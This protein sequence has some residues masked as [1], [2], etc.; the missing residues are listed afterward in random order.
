MTELLPYIFSNNYVIK[1]KTFKDEKEKLFKK[2]TILQNPIDFLNKKKTKI[3]KILS[4]GSF[5]QVYNIK[6]FKQILDPKTFTPNLSDNEDVLKSMLY[7]LNIKNQKNLLKGKQP[8]F[9]TIFKEFHFHKSKS[10]STSCITPQDS[11]RN[12]NT[13]KNFKKKLNF[14]VHLPS[15]FNYIINYANLKKDELIKIRNKVKENKKE[16]KEKNEKIE[17][18]Q[19]NIYKRNSN[20]LSTSLWE[21]KTEKLIEKY[22][23]KVNKKENIY[24]RLKEKMKNFEKGKKEKEKSQKIKIKKINISI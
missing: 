22:T 11:I 18:K 10:L 17:K 9:K 14:S 3:N 15:K 23:Q 21:S 24:K 4:S 20:Y 5:Y 12:L 7:N 1:N 16:E 2:F 19:K 13:K 8:L 6:N